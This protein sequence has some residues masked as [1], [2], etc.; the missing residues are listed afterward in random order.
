MEVLTKVR[1]NRNASIQLSPEL[2]E[3]ISMT[4]RGIWTALLQQ[5]SAVQ[6]CIEH[7]SSVYEIA[8]DGVTPM[9]VV[10]N[11]KISYSTP[12]PGVYHEDLS[13]AA[14]NNSPTYRI[15]GSF[16][17]WSEAYVT[18]RTCDA[19]QLALHARKRSLSHV[20]EHETPT[21]VRF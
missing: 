20:L 8:D 10:I 11:V 3:R 17:E 2:L 9:R 1:R 18:K 14:K 6:N 21:T 12:F 15:D 4:E 19:I 5:E 7:V 13:I 16:I